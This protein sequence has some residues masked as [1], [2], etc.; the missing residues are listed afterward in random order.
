MSSLRRQAKT[1]LYWTLTNTWFHSLNHQQ[2]VD[3][4]KHAASW[5]CPSL[6]YF[7]NFTNSFCNYFWSHIF[8][9]RYVVSSFISLE[10]NDSN[11]IVSKD[12]IVHVS[13]CMACLF[14]HQKK[15]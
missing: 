4:N 11:F 2:M 3:H 8:A 6:N 5:V 1:V 12:D 15:Y 9:Y 14:S 13:K 10:R 7:F